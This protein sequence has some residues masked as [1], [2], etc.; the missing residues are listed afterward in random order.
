MSSFLEKAGTPY[1]DA[2]QPPGA[3]TAKSGTTPEEL[4]AMFTSIK[5]GMASSHVDSLIPL[6]SMLRLRGK[7]YSL[8]DHFPFEPL[9][10]KNLTK[11][12]L[13]KCGRQVAKSTSIAASGVLRCAGQSWLSMLYVTPLSTQIRRLSSL[14]VKPFINHS[15]LKPVLVDNGCVQ[16]VYLREFSNASLMH[17]SFAYL[18]VERVR[19]IMCDWINFDEVQDMDWEYIPII[20]ESKSA[21][22]LGLS[23]YTGTPKSLDNTIEALWR[24]SSQA[25]WVTK[26]EACGY[27]SVAGVN[28]DLLKM[29]GKT[30]VVCARCSKPIQP[31]N[32]FW[33]HFREP[34]REDTSGMMFGYHVPQAI[35]PMHYEDVDKWKELLAKSEGRMGYGKSKF[36]NEVL[37]ESC[38]L[39]L[40]LVTETDIIAASK[41]GNTKNEFVEAC[42]QLSKSKLRIMGVDWGGGGAEG[43]SFTV[44]VLLGL[45]PAKNGR[46]DCYY[47]ERFPLSLSRDAEI[48]TILDYFRRSG[49][50]FIAHDYGGAG[51]VR[52]AILVQAGMPLE[53]IVNVAYTVAPKRNIF[54]WEAPVHGEVRGYFGLDKPRSL[55]LQAY[56]IKGGLITL[57]EYESSK[58]V[59]SD[60]LNLIEERKEV[61]RASDLVL[62]RRRPKFP[63]DFSHALNYG[64]VAM[65][66]KEQR[67]PDL[68]VVKNLQL[69]QEQLTFAKPPRNLTERD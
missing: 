46:I 38:D 32:G 68:T 11:R 63:D 49:C 64:C 5:D 54:Y 58:D 6:A 25:E 45:N 10:R 29:L 59:T 47:A 22:S 44:V 61:P 18:D 33:R 20:L 1:T 57:P 56:C 37:G 55:V 28:Y 60:L 48:A 43:T 39:G 53:R 51:D 9:F 3:L 8:K 35:M 27:H 65:W 62:I 42:R 13:Y 31:R 69:T 21:S 52:E 14:Y 2:Q 36:F 16:T 50:H 67:W 23:C 15:L 66:H 12:T 40:T 26:C 34:S 17:F 24:D 7:P 41:L 4:T 19:G 30:T